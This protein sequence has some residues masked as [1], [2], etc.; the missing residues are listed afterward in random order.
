MV[1]PLY[2]GS[3]GILCVHNLRRRALEH[4]QDRPVRLARLTPHCAG[5]HGHRQAREGAVPRPVAP[6][7]G[8]RVECCGG[9]G[10]GVAR[11]VAGPAA[12]GARVTT[13]YLVARSLRS[14]RRGCAAPASRPACPCRGGPSG[15]CVSP[16]CRPGRL[17][18]SA[19]HPWPRRAAAPSSAARARRP[20]RRSSRRRRAGAASPP[21]SSPRS[22][23]RSPSPRRPRSRR[24]RC[25]RRRQ[26]ARTPPR[27]TRPAPP[28]RRP[29]PAPP[30]RRPSPA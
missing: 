20:R 26:P 21:L 29:P 15:S 23:R 30:P 2:A 3:E 27:S 1:L 17:L 10:H 22:E 8:A 5:D 4:E 16:G 11:G 18:P 7:G 12:D 25:C 24:R 9:G 6:R 13:A 19:P 14:P 28:P